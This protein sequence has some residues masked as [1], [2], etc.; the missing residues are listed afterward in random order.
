MIGPP[1]W[2]RG[3]EMD[4]YLLYVSKG[5]FGPNAAEMT[6]AWPER[7]IVIPTAGA[8]ICMSCMALFKT[9][10]FMLLSP[11]LTAYRSNS[12]RKSIPCNPCKALVII[13]WKNEGA[14][15][16][17]KGILLNSKSPSG[18]VKA[19]HF[20]AS[21]TWGRRPKL[22]RG[23]H[24]IL[25]D[26]KLHPSTSQ[27][28]TSYLKCVSFS[29]EQ[30][31]AKICMKSETMTQLPASLCKNILFTPVQSCSI[32]SNTYHPRRPP[33]LPFLM[34]CHSC[35]SESGAVHSLW[36]RS[37]YVS[38]VKAIQLDRIH[39]EHDWTIP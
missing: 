16:R 33:L 13:D 39:K 20:F 29:Y 8:L 31:V 34:A 18:V 9:S 21:G 37:A 10:A 30:Q 36:W 15:F 25:T 7:S 3:M 32:R 6:S 24:K 14:F 23:W 27:L 5:D 38:L 12:S 4:L 1:G 11:S 22:L 28:L 2:I 26:Y 17:Q 19:V 35:I